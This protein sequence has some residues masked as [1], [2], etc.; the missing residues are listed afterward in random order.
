MAIVPRVT[1]KGAIRPLVTMKPLTAPPT[2]P[3]ATAT[4]TA[5]RTPAH[6]GLPALP[7]AFMVITP[8]APENAASDPTERSMPPPMMT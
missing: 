1:M 6:S 2:E 3:T 4:S 5:A 8:R 7:R